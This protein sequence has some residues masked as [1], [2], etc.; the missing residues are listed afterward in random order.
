MQVSKSVERT[1]SRKA[2]QST[3]TKRKKKEHQKSPE[4]Q[5]AGPGGG[6]GIKNKDIEAVPFP[7]LLQ[8]NPHLIDIRDQ[9]QDF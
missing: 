2:T 5:K 8:K 3:T 9:A 4:H 1:K 7:L 6:N